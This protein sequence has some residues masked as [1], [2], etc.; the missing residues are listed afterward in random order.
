MHPAPT[1][2]QAFSRV[3]VRVGLAVV[4]V[5]AVLAIPIKQRCGAP[6]LSCATAMDPQ[7]NVHYYY[8]VEPLG[9]YVAEIMT[10]SNITVFYES[11]EDLVK[12]R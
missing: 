7:G 8:E 6:G 9:V 2:R 5:L 1:T 11:G 3:P 4:V 10:G 12:A